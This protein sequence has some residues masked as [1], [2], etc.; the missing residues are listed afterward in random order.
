MQQPLS[1]PLRDTAMA[2][3][4]FLQADICALLTT[5]LQ[6]HSLIFTLRSYREAAI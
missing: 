5:L 3:R 1:L 2:E 6:D 4:I